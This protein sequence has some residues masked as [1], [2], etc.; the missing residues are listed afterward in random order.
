LGDKIVDLTA[1]MVSGRRRRLAVDKTGAS[2]N[3]GQR[4]IATLPTISRSITD[5]TR[6]TPQ[7]NG[8]NFAGRD[9]RYNNLQVD[10]ANLNNN[11]GLSTDPLPGGGNQPISLDAYEEISI[12]IAP[13]D[14]RQAGFT[15]AG[16]NAVTK[17]GTNTFRGTLYGYT[18]DQDLQGARI[19]DAKLPS[20]AK[21]KNSIYGATIGG[22]IIKN[23]L[24]FFVSGERE[25]RE[26]PGITFRPTG[27][28]G[29]GNE[30]STHIDSLRKLSD[31]VSQ[32]FGYE[33]GAYD[34]FPNFN[35]ENHKILAKLD[36]NINR[37]HKLTL[38]YN[39]LVS[40]NDVQLN[41]TSVPNGGGFAVVGGSGTLSRMPNNRF[42]NVSMGF[43]NSNYAFEDVVRS[44]SFEL[45]SNFGGKFSNQ[46]LAT[47]T[48]IQATRILD[49][50]V[51]P[52]VDIFN[53]NGQNYMHVGMDPFTYNN[54]VY[55]DVYSF[56]DNFSYFAGKHTITAGISYEKQKVGNMFMAASNSYYVFNSLDDFINDRAP[57]YYAYTYSLVPGQKTVYSAEL[58]VGQLGLYAQD[59]VN[60]SEKLKVIF[61]LRADKPIYLKD[62]IE[63]PS[64]S[65]LSFPDNEGSPKSYNT[66]KWPKSRTLFSPRVGFRWDMEG[67]K[68]M[69]LRGGT[70]VFTGRIPFVW[71]TN[72]P[73]NSGMYQFGALVTQAS[74]LEN[75]KFSTDPDVYRDSFPSV[76]G[77]SYPPSLV[78]ID[79]DFKFPQVWRTNI[80][81]DKRFG[82]GWLFSV[83]GIFTKDMNA[84]RMRNVNQKPTTSNFTGP[85]NRPRFSSTANS[86]RRYYSNITTAIVLENTSKGGGMTLTA[87]LAKSFSKG[88]YGSLAYTYSLY[89]EVSANPGSQAASV[90]NTNPN[91]GTQNDLELYNS[92]FI[93]PHRIVGILSYR[94]EYLKHLGTTVSLYYEGAAQGSYSYVYNGD[95]NLDG[96]NITDL[97]YIPRD[98]S[99]IIFR[100]ITSGSTVVHSAAAQSE[101]FFQ[102]VESTPYLRDRK[103]QYARRNGSYLPWYS[104]LDFKF[105][106]DVFTNIG[107]RKHTLQLSIDV[108][109]FGN[110][111]NKNWGVQKQTVLNNPL[112]PAG[113]DAQGR[114]TF[115][116][117]QIG[118]KLPT[119]PFQST[120]STASTW[121]AQLGLRYIF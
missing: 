47:L 44:G 101:A 8:N 106:Q 86:E 50:G 90:W 35:S 31:F 11:F 56:I 66:G 99:E 95:L 117:T 14:V 12:N 17:S 104:R 27:G 80:A 89:N 121:S 64:I 24:F 110:L 79:P 26:F 38:K 67:D 6:L 116:M 73:T 53:N 3:V 57:A 103:G 68:S 72:M 30:S 4:Q 46:F 20:Q 92:A 60:L 78:L 15:G 113:A 7:A 98:P 51:F 13:Y 55:N 74:R 23:K 111:L 96:N 28:T 85:D 32:K 41:N 63:N 77:A 82:N 69:I 36:W 39:E 102:F 97:L 54:D 81:V 108:F 21:Q 100:D 83:E 45:N 34:N 40:T 88:L 25:K 107:K 29:S 76:A 119:K 9:G 49:G 62:A 2:T 52:T 37:T 84:V 59:E 19:G 10:G 118:G 43:E 93:V 33:T 109:N 114:P 75:F 16:I 65:A 61:G 42:S 112:I 1:V 87:Q 22:P 71:L 91:I 18:R 5:F 115:R 48:K 105:L 94:I 58:E 70:G 120:L